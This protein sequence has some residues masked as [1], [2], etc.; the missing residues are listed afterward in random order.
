[1]ILIERMHFILP[2]I[3]IIIPDAKTLEFSIIILDY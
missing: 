1:M 3:E 2:K